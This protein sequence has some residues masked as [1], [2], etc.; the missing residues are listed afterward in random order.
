M[1][2][3]MLD[4][5]CGLKEFRFF[6]AGANGGTKI[7][8]VI[9]SLFPQVCFCPVGGISPTSYRGY[10][11]LENVLRTNGSWLAP[12][13]VLGTGGYDHIIKLACRAVEDTKQ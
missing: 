8:R 2:E 1:S 11:T 5:D 9:A 12:T 3:L 4:M 10:L 6:P 7:L 13:D